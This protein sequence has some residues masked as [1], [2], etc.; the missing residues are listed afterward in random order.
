[1]DTSTRRKRYVTRPP[2]LYAAKHFND[3]FLN[4]GFNY[5]GQIIKKGSSPELHANP[6]NESLFSALDS[7]LYFLIQHTKVIKKWFSIAHSKND[8]NIN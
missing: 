1:M 6:L 5:R 3:V 4:Q 2:Y 8:I 7:M